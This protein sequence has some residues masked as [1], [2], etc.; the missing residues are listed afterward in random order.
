[1]ATV[2]VFLN[3]EVPFAKKTLFFAKETENSREPRGLRIVAA[4]EQ[5]YIIVAALD[6]MAKMHGMPQVAGFFP[7]KSR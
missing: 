4:L 5:I 3:S 7:Q 6:R 2:V 1:V